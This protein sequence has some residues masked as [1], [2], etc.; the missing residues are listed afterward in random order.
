MRSDHLARRETDYI[1]LFS[2]KMIGHINKTRSHI[3]KV[4]LKTLYFN[5]FLTISKPFSPFY[6]EETIVKVL[7]FQVPLV[8]YLCEL[9]KPQFQTN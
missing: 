1:F 2:A 3:H 8:S 5:F 4:G 9:T 6:L 7:W